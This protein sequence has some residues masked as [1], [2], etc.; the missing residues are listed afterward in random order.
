MA[1]TRHRLRSRGTGT[2]GAREPAAARGLLGLLAR[3]LGRAPR[4]AGRPARRTQRHGA[5][6]TA[7][8]NG[9]TSTTPLVRFEWEVFGESAR[10]T[11]HRRAEE[12]GQDAHHWWVD[13][14]RNVLAAAVADG[15]GSA[16]LGGPGAEL[17]ARTAV[18]ALSEAVQRGATD[19]EQMLR[20]ALIHAR[21]ALETE[22]RSRGCALQ[23]LSTTLIVLIAEPDRGAI[24]Q[25]GDGFAVLAD[26]DHQPTAHSD[27]QRGEFVN[28]TVFLTDED[29][30]YRTVI[31]AWDQSVHAVAMLTDGLQRLAMQLSHNRPHTPFF[32]SV[33]RT[34]NLGSG[35][36]ARQLM[37]FLHSRRLAERTDDDVTLLVAWCRRIPIPLRRAPRR[38]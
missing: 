3:L 10:G 5:S 33:F 24:A 37:R 22:A 34:G 2:R 26:A 19:F 17:A 18:E 38:R 13:T 4:S 36:M 9:A 23:D 8:H 11:N 6:G 14:E 15:A 30:L 21:L 7:S 29:A 16:K 31:R 35:D 20:H 12:P 25:L 28:E 27:P 1:Q 32:Q